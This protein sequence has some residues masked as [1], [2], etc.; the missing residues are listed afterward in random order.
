[1]RDVKW[2]SS[3]WTSRALKRV[4]TWTNLIGEWTPG[5]CSV[6]TCT[7]PPGY[8]SSQHR[9]SQFFLPVRYP[10]APLQMAN[11][12]QQRDSSCCQLTIATED[13]RVINRTEQN[14]RDAGCYSREGKNKGVDQNVQVCQLREARKYGGGI[15]QKETWSFPTSFIWILI[16]SATSVEEGSN[17]R[18]LKFFN[19][20]VQKLQLCPLQ[21]IKVFTFSF[22]S[23]YSCGKQFLGLK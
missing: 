3:P 20:A 12:K 2:T 15:K 6:Q 1:M 14:C 18:Q 10:C 13:W 21:S 7:P 19:P 8:G 5:S 9:L 17:S 4:A 11:Y 22:L 16:F 23:V